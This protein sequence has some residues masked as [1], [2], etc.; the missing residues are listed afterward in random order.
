M[1]SRTNRTDA[2]K[3]NGNSETASKPTKTARENTTPSQPIGSEASKPL[4]NE[5]NESKNDRD[6]EQADWDKIKDSKN[7]EDFK[8]YLKK[9]PNGRFI[10]LAQD[11]INS[12]E[13]K[14]KPLQS[15]TPLPDTIRTYNG[16]YYT[17]KVSEFSL[18]TF[19]I[20]M[21]NTLG[22]NVNVPVFA[23][24]VEKIE[25]SSAYFDI[26][27]RDGSTLK[28]IHVVSFQNKQFITM[29][30]SVSKEFPLP[31]MG[32][33]ALEDI[34]SL[35]APEPGILTLMPFDLAVE[36]QAGIASKASQN[37]IQPTLSDKS[38]A[39]PN[40]S[41]ALRYA[42]LIA[43]PSQTVLVLITVTNTGNR[44]DQFRLETDLPKDY[45]PSFSLAPGDRHASSFQS[46]LTP[47]LAPNESVEMVL[48]IYIP[49]KI[50]KDRKRGFIV[51]ATSQS[52][53]Q[54][55]RIAEGSIKAVAASLSAI[56]RIS[57]ET[58]PTELTS[59][60]YVSTV[61]NGGT[62]TQTITVHNDGRMLAKSLRADFVLGSAFEL[63][64]ASPSPLVYDPSSRTATWTLGDLSPQ[65]SREILMTLRF[66][67]PFIFLQS[68]IFPPTSH[69]GDLALHAQSLF[70]GT[71]FDTTYFYVGPNIHIKDSPPSIENRPN[72]QAIR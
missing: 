36:S 71:D 4:A 44:E 24:E 56:M 49:R 12:L 11:R 20:V 22:G 54:V 37:S 70:D 66:E 5:G 1:A 41:L 61:K 23:S 45:L 31:S 6:Y 30:E 29:S 15:P 16:H 43:A 28:N 62:F 42:N 9:Y 65:D 27:K 51:R 48:D 35:K 57:T 18:Y 64:S 47:K 17:G 8:A 53:N 21:T 25:F 58:P 69:I 59:G 52:A 13:P 40:L 60:L 10:K 2:T 3:S 26:Y 19:N 14:P 7:A 63:V 67:N 72:Q 55:F 32:V 33:L 39:V 34:T 50:A 68:P 46:P 38:I